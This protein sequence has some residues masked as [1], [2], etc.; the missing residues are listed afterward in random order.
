MM[1]KAMEDNTT[2]RAEKNKD[3]NESPKLN[4]NKMIKKALPLK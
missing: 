1:K 4:K 2:V 3:Q